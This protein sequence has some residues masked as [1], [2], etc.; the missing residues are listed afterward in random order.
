MR[1]QPNLLNKLESLLTKQKPANKRDSLVLRVFRLLR[2]TDKRANAANNQQGAA[3]IEED[4][5]KAP[6]PINAAANQDNHHAGN[7]SDDVGDDN[8]RGCQAVN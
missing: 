2:Q 3:D 1:R 6:C 4:V 5:A 7:N 8:M